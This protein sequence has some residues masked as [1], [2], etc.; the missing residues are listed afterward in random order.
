M[1]LF[2]KQQFCLLVILTNV[3]IEKA[4]FV[5]KIFKFLYLTLPFFFPLPTI[6]KFKGETDLRQFLYNAN[7]SPNRNL[8]KK[9]FNSLRSKEDLMVKFAS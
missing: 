4:L 6:S 5:L 8:K 9:L 1:Q 7:V 2:L 3:C